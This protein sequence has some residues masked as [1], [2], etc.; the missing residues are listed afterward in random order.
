MQLSL[1][2]SENGVPSPF[3]KKCYPKKS[4]SLVP[5]DITNFCFPEP[6]KVSPGNSV[7][8]I[9][10]TTVFTSDRRLYGFC[11]RFLPP[12]ATGRYD[13]EDRYPVVYCFISPL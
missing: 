8:T 4:S 1:R 10:Y 3:L 2:C 9:T 5:N 7:E 13:L 12:T 6:L 11:K